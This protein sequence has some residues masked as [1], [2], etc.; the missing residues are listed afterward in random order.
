MPIEVS[1]IR[2]RRAVCTVELGPDASVVFEYRPVR[3]AELIERGDVDPERP[4]TLQESREAVAAQLVDITAAWDVTREGEPFP[5]D[6]LEIADTFDI[7]F[8]TRCFAG[9]VEHYATGK[10][11]GELLSKLG[12]ATTSPRDGAESSPD[13]VANRVSRRSASSSKSRSKATSPRGSLKRIPNGMTSS[14]PAF[15]PATAS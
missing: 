8:L 10:T 15:R 11:T 7:G 3:I 4:D 14:P 5:L 12:T 9:L 2:D 1:A 13:G 6:A